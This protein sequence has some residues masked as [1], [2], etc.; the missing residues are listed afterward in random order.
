M[1]E[2]IARGLRHAQSQGGYIPEAEQ[3][4]HKN[5]HNLAAARLR[6]KALEHQQSNLWKRLFEME[7]GFPAPLDQPRDIPGTAPW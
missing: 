2:L 5:V 3:Q 7:E 4:T 6:M 1:S